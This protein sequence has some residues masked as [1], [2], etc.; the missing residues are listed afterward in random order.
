M[1]FEFI[2]FQFLKTIRSVSLARNLLGGFFILLFGFI[3]L[4]SLSL[5]AFALPYI[6]REVLGQENVVAFL[7]SYLLFFF[8][9]EIMY[10]FFLQKLPVI[11]LENF[12][13]LPIKKSKII[14]FI[15]GRSFF[16]VNSVIPLLLFVPVTIME[17]HKAFG[18][19]G[20]IY[21]L[22]LI[23][24][25]SWALHWF[26]LW[27]KQRY[28]NDLVGI[29]I[30][31]GLSLVTIGSAYYGWLNMG[32]IAAP[33]FNWALE[34][35]VPLLIGV[36]ALAGSY[37]LTFT[38][39]KK[40]AY[41][42]EFWQK[43]GV[44]KYSDGSME[45]LSRF[46]L[47]GEMADIEW[48]LILR[49]KKSKSYL[50]ISFLFLFYGLYF[51]TDPSFQTDTGFSYFYIF[52]GIF[53]TG[54]FIVQYGQLFLSWNSASFDFYLCRQEG[55]R[56]LI[57]GK[58]L[59]FMVI[60]LLCFLL[61]TPYVYFG[62]DI[63]LVHTATFLF[64]MGV[65]IHV[66]SYIALWQPKPMNLNKGAFFNYEGVGIAQFLMGI[67]IF[68]IPY[69]IFLPP[70]LLVNGYFGLVV[71]GTVGALGIVFYEKLIE[72][73]V[74]KLIRNRHKISSTFRQEI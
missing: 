70:A 15:L 49:H 47:T 30:L 46:G 55:L 67:P 48:R 26:V 2:R 50:V 36:G 6:I 54:I 4:S 23:L 8:T 51:Y 18:I 60:S 37:I 56:S 11:E 74:K 42:E 22:G 64:N 29:A 28:G 24:V 66:I 35:P 31:F 17:V 68:L 63:L 38:F 69:I 65:S 3:I 71:L 7:N 34:S 16:S 41:I 33:L 10:R 53:V 43:K 62:W 5:T 32:A 9:I 73:S 25:I 39:Y 58:Y 45:F 21:W 61:S 1:V 12:L 13:H 27:Y 44:A 20:S 52:V 59:L 72:L 14:H 19:A 57:K 40:N